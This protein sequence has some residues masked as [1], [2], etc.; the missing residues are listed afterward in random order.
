MSLSKYKSKVERIT[1]SVRNLTVRHNFYFQIIGSFLILSLVSYLHFM[2][3]PSLDVISFALVDKLAHFLMFFFTMMWF[4]YVSKKWLL[5]AVSLLLLALVLE[6]IQMNYI[7]NR[8]F[9]W[10]DWIADGIGIVLCFLLL[11]VLIDKYFDNS[12]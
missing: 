1:Q 7:I 5:T 12:V 6:W 10:F 3:P 11:P 8:S 2:Q 9:D 4:M